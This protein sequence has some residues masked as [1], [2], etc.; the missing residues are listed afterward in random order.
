VLLIVA[1]VAA[2][3]VVSAATF[4]CSRRRQQQQSPSQRSNALGHDVE[5]GVVIPSHD[6]NVIF[7]L[8]NNRISV[9]FF[10]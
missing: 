8:A 4:L 7:S 5:L 3:V 1:S 6:P 2:L 9:N 10:Y